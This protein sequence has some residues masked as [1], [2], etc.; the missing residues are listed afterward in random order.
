MCCLRAHASTVKLTSV[1][2]GV[3]DACGANCLVSYPFC[4]CVGNPSMILSS[5]WNGFIKMKLG[6]KRLCT[7]SRS[8]VCCIHGTYYSK[9]NLL[10]PLFKFGYHQFE[11][12]TNDLSRSVCQLSLNPTLNCYIIIIIKIIKIGI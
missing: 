5:I 11:W 7:G 8:Y 9:L 6:R 4:S 12:I 1:L 3:G 2:L 10:N